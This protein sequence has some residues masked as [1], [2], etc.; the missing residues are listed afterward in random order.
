VRSIFPLWILEIITE[1]SNVHQTHDYHSGCR[2][3]SRLRLCA[4]AFA[5]PILAFDNAVT[6]PVVAIAKR[7]SD[8]IVTFA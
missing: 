4:G 1:T 6:Q 7:K 3:V 5:I 8:A 2:A